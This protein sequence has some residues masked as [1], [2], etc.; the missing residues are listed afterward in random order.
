MK[1]NYRNGSQYSTT[2]DKVEPTM[3]DL[4]CK[5][6]EKIAVVIH[7]WKESFESEW[8]P[9]LIQNLQLYRGG[10]VIF[11]DYSVHSVVLDYF[12]LLSKFDSI[13]DVLIRKLLLLE[14]EG[15]DPDNFYIFGFSFGAHLALNSGITF[16][17]GKIGQ[18]DGEIMKIQ[19]H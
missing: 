10:C 6:D 13:G 17:D 4:G 3:T 19:L 18:I 14:K 12:E 2:I 9:V 15:F 16:G 1:S 11:M 5:V 7:G 8:V